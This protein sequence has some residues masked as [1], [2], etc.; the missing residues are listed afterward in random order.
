MEHFANTITN[1]LDAKGRV[2]LPAK[3]R[4][5]LSEHGAE[6][7]FII[8]SPSLTA[9]EAFGP[10]LRAE[11][12]ARLAV[13]D[14]FSEDYDAFAQAF[15]GSSVELAW[16]TEGRIRLPDHFLSYAKITDEVVFAGLGRKFQIWDPAGFEIH[17]QRMRERAHEK[18]G[19]L[20]LRGL[21]GQK[22]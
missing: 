2:S 14:P 16:D 21:P 12:N 22:P 11:L 3:F 4:Q 5:V 6:T 8:Q 20:D 10:G 1:R 13:F 18:R 17:R 19:L 7:V 15:F 9:L